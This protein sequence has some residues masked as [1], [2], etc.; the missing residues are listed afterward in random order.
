MSTLYFR[1]KQWAVWPGRGQRDSGPSCGVC[2]QQYWMRLCRGSCH[3]IISALYIFETNNE[4]YGLVEDKEIAARA[5][6]F[7]VNSTG[8]G[9][10]EDHVN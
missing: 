2:C 8:L 4:L 7:V 3:L 10:V 6:A 5:V 9:F 1:N